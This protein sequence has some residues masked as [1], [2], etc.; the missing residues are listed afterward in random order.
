[1]INQP[2]IDPSRPQP[3][4]RRLVFFRPQMDFAAVKG[5]LQR[6]VGINTLDSRE[7]NG[8]TGEMAETLSRGGAVYIDPND[9]HAGGFFTVPK[10]VE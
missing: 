7:F 6:T 2:K 9:R 3:T 1:M 8:S 5:A 10:V 4:G